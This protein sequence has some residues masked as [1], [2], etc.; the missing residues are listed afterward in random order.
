[1]FEKKIEKNTIPCRISHEIDP[2]KRGIERSIIEL[3]MLDFRPRIKRALPAH[4]DRWDWS[5]LPFWEQR[6]IQGSPQDPAP[7]PSCLGTTQVS[8]T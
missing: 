4:R 5:R 8:G 6:D 3:A 2:T 1:M 7:F